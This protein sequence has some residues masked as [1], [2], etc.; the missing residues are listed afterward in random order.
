M[1]QFTKPLATVNGFANLL[2]LMQAAGYTGTA[3]GHYLRIEN[4]NAGLVYI[5]LTNNG[6]VAPAVAADG[7]PIANGAGA[8]Q[9]FFE[10][11][12]VTGDDGFIDLA[13]IWIGAGAVINI[14]VAAIGGGI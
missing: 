8:V 4:D 3:Q 13:G 11:G 14:K 7:I 10:V 1:S 9:K 2:T 6:S 5:H 12:S